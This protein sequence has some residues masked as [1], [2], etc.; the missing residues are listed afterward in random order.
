MEESAEVMDFAEAAK[1]VLGDDLVSV[2]LFGS[3]ARGQADGW[4]DRDVFL[5]IA[6]EPGEETLLELALAAPPRLQFQC[7]TPEQ[8]LT[9]IRNL[10]APQMAMV[11]EGVVIYGAGL[12]PYRAALAEVVAQH[13][14]VRRPEL[15]KGVWEAGDRFPPREA[16]AKLRE[17]R[18]ALASAR[19]LLGEGHEARSLLACQVAV[20]KLLGAC[21][22]VKF[23]GRLLLP[24][25]SLLAL[26]EDKVLGQGSDVAGV[27]DI[28]QAHDAI[29]GLR[30]AEEGLEFTRRFLERRYELGVFQMS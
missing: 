8:L 20:E 12:E 6:H 24:R 28:F 16:L 3:W 14:L 10:R 1:Q 15:G 7:H 26:L 5:I 27:L 2:V 21:L 19:A 29:E 17:V 4:S 11:D 18:Q 9:A 25:P 13:G 30:I 22:A 23:C